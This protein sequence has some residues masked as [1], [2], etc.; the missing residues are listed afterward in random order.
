[1]IVNK[2]YKYRIYPDEN[3][4]ILLAKT[5]GCCRLMWNR[6]LS[7]RDRAYEES[8][9][10]INPTPASY[11]KEY[12]FLKEVDSLSLCNV[13]MQLNRAYRNFYKNPSHFSHPHFH[14]KKFSRKSYTTNMVNGNIQVNDNQIRLPKL[15]IVKMKK[16]RELPENGKI[17]SVTVSMSASGKY[18]A[19]ILMEIE[20]E[21]P[22]EKEILSSV[23]L[24]YMMHGLYA[25][26]EGNT[27]DYPGYYRQA[28]K[29]L[30]REQRKLSHMVKGSNNWYRQK[31]KIAILHEKAANK[32]KDFL[33]KASKYLADRYDLVSIEDLNMQ[34]M[35]KALNFGKSVSDNGWGMFT[36]MLAYKLADRNK[37]LVKVDKFFASSQTC[38]VCGY[39]NEETKDLSVRKWEC[40]R[41]HAFHDRDINAAV[42]I[43]NEGI[44]MLQAC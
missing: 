30:A 43:R 29:K 2:G 5:F 28:E 41:C 17:K 31:R 22:R 39:K 24:D 26:S 11:K 12:P 19:S 13:Q 37:K 14:S 18:Y 34:G 44:R 25:D 27:A 6:M 36:D 3:Q 20:K 35:S 21:D 40:P 1:M 42:N 33:H 38:S 15:G 23:G 7:D 32:R 16:H 9:K 4:K 8:K 10:E